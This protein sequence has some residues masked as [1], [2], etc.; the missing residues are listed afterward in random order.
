MKNIATQVEKYTDSL[1]AVIILA[2]GTVP[3]I[4]V[5]TDY[6]LSFLSAISLRI[7][8]KNVCS[9]LTNLSS[10][11]F[12]NFPGDAVPDI[13]KTAPQFLL[14]NPVALQKKY[15]KLKSDQNMKTGWTDLPQLVKADEQRALEMLADLFDWLDGTT[16][17]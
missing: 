9:I 10:V 7:P 13:L 2:N 8:V 6:A 5:G 14:N 1:N 17:L 11:L 16:T 3:R 12:Q 15:L 4:T